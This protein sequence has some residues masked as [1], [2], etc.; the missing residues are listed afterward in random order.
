MNPVE[1]LTFPDELTL[2]RAAAEAWLEKIAEAHL[3]VRPHCVALAG[4]RAA[5][6]L[7]P[8]VAEGSRVRAISLSSVDFFWGDERCVP[9]HDPESNFASARQLLLQPLGVAVEKIHR[10]A[11]EKSSDAATREA[12]TEL[13]R[14]VRPGAHGLPVLDLIFLGMGEDG[15]V[16]SLFPEEAAAMLSAPEI[17]RPVIATKPPP[18]RITLGYPVLA[19]A[20][21]VWVLVS[22]RDKAAALKKSLSPDGH[23]PLARLLRLRAHTRIF[24]DIPVS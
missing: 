11:G 2:A 4:G 10:I 20:H 1:L 16:A 12:V 8:A 24:T 7:Y 18:H 14:I 9:P 21:E 15:H 22:G 23:T 13:S 19:A 3:H 6:S 5:R 17:Y